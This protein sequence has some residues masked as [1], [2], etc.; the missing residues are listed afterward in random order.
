MSFSPEFNAQSILVG[1][2]LEIAGNMEVSP[3]EYRAWT[4]LIHASNYITSLRESNKERAIAWLEANG[5]KAEIEWDALTLT[6]EE[7]P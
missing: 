6:V 4:T 1:A 3:S 2:R 7:E 5:F